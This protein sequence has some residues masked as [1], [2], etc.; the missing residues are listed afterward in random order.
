MGPCPQSDQE[1]LS[2]VL[3]WVSFRACL[4]GVS[5]S[6]QAMTAVWKLSYHHPESLWLPE[7]LLT[8]KRMQG[9]VALS[10]Y[11]Q[12]CHARRTSEATGR[13]V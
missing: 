5:F 1:Q 4:G 11:H 7:R 9:Q 3:F 6:K 2:N 13:Q 8:G 10:M 12:P